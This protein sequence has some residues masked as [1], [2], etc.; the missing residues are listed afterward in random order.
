MPCLM[1]VYVRPD[2]QNREGL[3][4]YTAEGLKILK[5]YGGRHIVMGGNPQCL[6][7]DFPWLL[8]VISEWPDREAALRFWNSPE[9]TAV[10]KHREG[11]GDYQIVLVDSI[12]APT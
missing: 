11:T 9:Y 4:T 6:E 2:G 7:G 10:K 12:P 8:V 3:R 5:Q 1:L